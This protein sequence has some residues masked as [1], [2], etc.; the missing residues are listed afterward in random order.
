[1]SGRRA[2]IGLCMLFA[3]LVSAVGAQ[4]AVAKRI[5]HNSLDM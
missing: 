4:S 1:M 2:V 5:R 3:L